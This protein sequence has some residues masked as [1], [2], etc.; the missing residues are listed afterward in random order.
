M[1]TKTSIYRRQFAFA[2]VLLAVVLFT[3]CSKKVETEIEID[4][5]SILKGTKHISTHVWIRDW[6]GKPLS[7]EYWRVDEC[8][9]LEVDSVLKIHKKESSII[10]K[11]CLNYR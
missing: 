10:S 3:S 5:A 4:D 9:A 6:K 8:K 1:K 11:A 2:Y 7:L